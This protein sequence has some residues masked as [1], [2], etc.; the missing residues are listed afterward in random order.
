MNWDH[1]Q[2]SFIFVYVLHYLKLISPFLYYLPNLAQLTLKDPAKVQMI[3][4]C[5]RYLIDLGI[6]SL[7]TYNMYLQ[8][9]HE[10]FEDHGD[11]ENH[12][13]YSVH[14]IVG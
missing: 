10:L 14:T 13:S 1:I 4:G 6:I 7:F 2:L 3:D 9:G 12:H 8:S 11:Y 5:P